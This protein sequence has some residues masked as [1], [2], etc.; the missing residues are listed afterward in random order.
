M[1]LA[2][3]SH[4]TPEPGMLTT[5]LGLLWLNFEVYVLGYNAEPGGLSRLS[6]DL[7]AFFEGVRGR[8]ELRLG[9]TILFLDFNLYRTMDVPAVFGLLF[10]HVGMYKIVLH[11][12]K[13]QVDVS[14]FGTA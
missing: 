3:A 8:C 2:D 5:P 11:R 9:K 10:K 12:G 1:R 14:P 4:Y 13:A 7:R 6:A